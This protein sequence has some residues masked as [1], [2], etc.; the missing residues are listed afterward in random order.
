MQDI[1]RA[2]VGET[3]DAVADEQKRCLIVKTTRTNMR[4]VE[5]IA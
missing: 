3:G 5:S 4:R 2:L 1:L